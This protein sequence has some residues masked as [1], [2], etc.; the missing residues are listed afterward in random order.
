MNPD[1]VA[2]NKRQRRP[3]GYSKMNNPEWLA[4]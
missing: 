4:A 1:E 2:L 3:K